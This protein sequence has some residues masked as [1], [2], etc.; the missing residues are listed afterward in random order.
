M[1]ARI[2]DG[3]DVAARLRA[4]V[5]DRVLA[6]QKSHGVSPHLAVIL[7]GEHSAS[8][9]YV[10]AKA[11]A[12]AAAGIKV[13]KH[14]L[15][16]S[17]SEADLAQLV[18]TKNADNDIHGVLVQLPLPEHIRTDWILNLLDP[19]KDVDGFTEL[20][21]GR[22][23]MGS[24][25]GLEAC[26]PQGCLRLIR[27]ALEG[28]PLAGLDAVV[29]G[30]SRIVG[31]PMAAMLM[32]EDCSVTVVHKLS[33]HIPEVCRLADIIV[34]AAG[35]PAL[36]KRDWVKP[37]AVVIDVGINRL[38]AAEGPGRIVG[39][40]DFAAVSEVAGAI[41]PVPGGVGPMTIAC[42]LA[43]VTL[44]AERTLAARDEDGAF[45]PRSAAR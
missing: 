11:K 8:H 39:D 24:H 23:L 44:A 33:R 19:D 40:V 45:S 35:S 2:I 27:E 13:S 9:I 5:A 28:R 6:L 26:T 36:V 1:K 3:T 16:Q 38:T 29:I 18:K 37:G 31:T 10:R 4:Q 17:T 15:P 21:A 22:V 30:R 41:T 7:V 42:L 43:N 34:V 14:V 12:A 32:R 25:A 20:N